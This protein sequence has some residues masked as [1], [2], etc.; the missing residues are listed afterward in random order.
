MWANHTV[1]NEAD[2]VLDE[3]HVVTTDTKF[4]LDVH[5]PLLNREV[6]TSNVLVLEPIVSTSCHYFAGNRD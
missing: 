1:L 6:V 3:A 4:E 2:E 5:L